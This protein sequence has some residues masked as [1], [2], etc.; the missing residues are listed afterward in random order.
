MNRLLGKRNSLPMKYSLRGYSLERSCS[1][2][3]GMENRRWRASV[4]AS[5]VMV[6]KWLMRPMHKQ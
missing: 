5:V 3:E 1:G 2:I 6:V 4:L